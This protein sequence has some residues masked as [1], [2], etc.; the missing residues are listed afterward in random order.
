MKFTDLGSH[1]RLTELAKNPPDLTRASF[2]TPERIDKMAVEALSWKMLYATEAVD[3]EVEKALVRLSRE[4]NVLEKMAFLQ[5]MQVMNYVNNCESEERRVGHTAIRALEVSPYASKELTAAVDAAKSE[6]VKLEAFLPKVDKFKAMVVVGIGGS[7]LGTKAVLEALKAYQQNGRKLYFASNVDPDKIQSILQE[8][9]LATTLIVIV[10]KSGGTLEIAA[11]E[12]VLRR[13]Y[14]KEKLDVKNH[15][16]MITTQK[17]LMDTPSAYLETFYLWDYIGGRYSVSSMVGAVP[18]SFMLGLSIWKEFLRGLHEMD[19][20]ARYETD[21]KKNLPLWGALLGVWNHN[22]LKRGTFAIIPYAQGMYAWTEHLQ[23]LFMESNGKSVSQKDG[24]FI[25]WQTAPVLW[26]TVGTEGQHSYYQAIH[27]GTQV[28]PVEFVGFLESQ[29]G[30][31]D[32]IEGTTNQEKLLANLFA[33]SLAL[34]KGQKD[35]N[36]NRYFSG[37]RPNHILLANRLDAYTLGNLLAYYEHY[38][39]FQGFLWNINSFD[40]EGVQLGK[41]LAND[42]L[43][44]IK[45]LHHDKP[46][47]EPVKDRMLVHAFLQNLKNYTTKKS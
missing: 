22:F 3:S 4:A 18:I 36:H 39:A 23:Q 6:M 29:F 42:F 31:D 44:L 7:Y 43:E 8:V 28:V 1:K 17:S 46:S 40:Q 27:Q 15:F 32:E 20:H 10:S 16:V 34:A 37:S 38:V 47:K 33:Q 12:E 24:S 9:E 35:V 45:E 25:D 21:P 5:E 26:G 19:L 30:L 2:L 41:R 13:S 14:A 11:Q